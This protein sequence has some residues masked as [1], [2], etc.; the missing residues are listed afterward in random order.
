MNDYHETFSNHHYTMSLI[1]QVTK[2]Q[3]SF[4]K[5]NCVR[6]KKCL[7]KRNVDPN[8]KTI[9]TISDISSN[10]S[11]FLSKCWS[12]RQ[13]KKRYTTGLYRNYGSALYFIAIKN[14][15]NL[16]TVHY[17]LVTINLMVCAYKSLSFRYKDFRMKKQD[18][19][20]VIMHRNDKFLLQND[21]ILNFLCF[22]PFYLEIL[23]F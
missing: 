22:F 18:R 1:A 16:W 9:K 21:T 12:M 4:P 11:L 8:N 5:N 6:C 17:T 15:V 14:I 3:N 2:L 10:S 7:E 23:S 20:D 19:M 13:I